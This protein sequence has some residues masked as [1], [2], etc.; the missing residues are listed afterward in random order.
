M[1]ILFAFFALLS[2][3]FYPLITDPIPAEQ[4]LDNVIFGTGILF[5]GLVGGILVFKAITSDKKQGIRLL[6][7]G[8]G[9]IAVSLTLIFTIAGPCLCMN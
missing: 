9:L 3:V 5:V 6:V 4:N 8:F 2:G 7:S 1:Y